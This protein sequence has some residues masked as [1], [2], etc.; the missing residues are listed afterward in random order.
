MI[1]APPP[2]PRR[3]PLVLGNWKMHR[4]GPDGAELARAILREF[5]GRAPEGVGVGLLPPFPALA[6]VGAAI[7]GTGI[8]LGAQ[9]CHASESGAFTGSVAAE[10]LFAWKCAFVLCGHSERRRPGGEDDAAVRAKVGAALRAGIGPVLCVGETLEERE[11]GRTGE[12]LARQVAAG[13]AGLG[14]ADA[15][16]LEIA[17]EPVWAIG[18]GR[19]ASPQQA[20]DG[21]RAVRESVA[22]SLGGDAAAAVRVLYGGSVNPGIAAALMA[23]P[24]VDGALVG[25]ASL[26]AAGFAAIVRAAVPETSGAALGGK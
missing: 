24:G 12:V 5:G 19:T 16:R 4:G 22:R 17:Y 23:A 10:M 2:I 26:D 21:H 7:E 13:V 25:G 15:A 6:A 18:T 9:D 14:P 3:R 11:A 1:V 8:R 20:A